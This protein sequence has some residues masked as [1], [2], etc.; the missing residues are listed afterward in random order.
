M[1]IF[2]SLFRRKISLEDQIQTLADCGIRANDGFG[3]EYFLS[4]FGRDAYEKDPFVALLCALGGESEHEP[5]APVSSNVW[6][7][8][9]ECIEDHGSYVR[10]AQRMATLAG[11]ALP[12][13][14]ITDYVDLEEG[15]A[16]LSFVLAGQ[17]VRWEP[18]VNDDW[19]DPEILTRFVSLLAGQKTTRLF[20]YLDLKGQDCII[21]FS[22][23][24]QFSA[25]RKSTSLRFEWLK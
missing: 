1:S 22:T 16:T 9:T 17:E 25:L 21:G 15:K 24:E 13:K 20:T 7:L 4:T 2:D 18:K 12:L 19:I 3:S 11:D 10:I 14:D 8:D 6:H 5:H 23:S